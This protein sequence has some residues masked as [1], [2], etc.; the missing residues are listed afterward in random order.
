VTDGGEAGI[1]S[2]ATAEWKSRRIG[3]G[4]LKAKHLFDSLVRNH[5]NQ[6]GSEENTQ[7]ALEGRL[8]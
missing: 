7:A 2:G 4:H 3:V 8:R 1:F 5:H 6:V